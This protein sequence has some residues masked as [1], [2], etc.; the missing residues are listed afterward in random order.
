MAVDLADLVEVLKVEVNP[1]GENLF[2]TCTDDEWV[3]R[4]S[5]AF[6]NARIDGFLSGYVEEDGEVF[7]TSGDVDMPRDL[8]QVIVFLAALNA[9]SGRL[10][11]LQ[12]MFR[13]KAGPAEFEV[14][15]SA[16]VLKDQGTMLY[17]RYKIILSRL[18]DVGQVPDYVIDA[19]G[20][21]LSTT[22]DPALWPGPAASSSR[23]GW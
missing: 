23:R 17:E 15:R 13:A 19:V 1:P 10:R 5:S 3:V 6:W 9:L 7:P 14:Q 22:Y 21:R 11:E 2:P 16:N 8:Q 12:T 20:A 4:L 18:S